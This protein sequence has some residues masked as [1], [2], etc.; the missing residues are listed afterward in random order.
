M[1]GNW[2][3]LF[4][5]VNPVKLY[6]CFGHWLCKKLELSSVGQPLSKFGTDQLC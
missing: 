3:R 1:S 6:H 5:V 4:R 2:F